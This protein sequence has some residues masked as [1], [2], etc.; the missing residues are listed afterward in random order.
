MSTRIAELTAQLD[1]AVAEL[2]NQST[3]LVEK[4]IKVSASKGRAAAQ[5]VKKIAQELRGALQEHKESLGKA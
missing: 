4:G 1:V 3:R 2:K 5:D